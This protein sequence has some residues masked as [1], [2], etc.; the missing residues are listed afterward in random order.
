MTMPRPV[1][2]F[3]ITAIDNLNMICQ[4]EALLSKTKSEELDLHYHNIAH[5]GAQGARSIKSVNNPPGGLIHEFVPF[6]FAPRSPM[7]SAIHHGRVNNCQYDQT[8]IIYFETTIE[9]ALKN[10]LQDF[11]FY[12]RNATLDYSQCFTDLRMLSS[13]VDWATMTESPRLDGFCK[14]FMNSHANPRYVDRVEKRQAEFLIKE[15]V[16]LTLMTRIGVLNQA[17][18]QEVNAILA[19]NGVNLAVEVMT[20]WYF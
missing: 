13:S 10:D 14:Y 15:K 2:L 12:D 11:V 20:D 1:R 8:G 19:R 18:A 17:R 4:Q 6:Y 3:H 9:L 7:L 16:P 5:G